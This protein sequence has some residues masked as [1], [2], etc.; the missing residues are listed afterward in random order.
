MIGFT[1]KLLEFEAATE[2]RIDCK[3][4]F[5]S[6]TAINHNLIAAGKEVDDDTRANVNM[7]TAK[8]EASED[9]CDRAWSDLIGYAN[10]EEVAK[11]E[12]GEYTMPYC[13]GWNDAIDTANTV[14][15]PTKIEFVK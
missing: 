4:S 3:R 11:V 2:Y 9:R 15:A 1:K 12:T 5:E 7:A 14:D 6:W 13:Q 8:M 10:R